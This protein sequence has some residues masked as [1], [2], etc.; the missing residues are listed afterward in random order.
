V[1]GAN[2]FVQDPKVNITQSTKSFGEL[3]KGYSGQ[4]DNNFRQNFGVALNVPIFSNGGSARNAYER[5]KLNVQNAQL[6]ITQADLQLKQDIYQAYT[7]ASAAMQRYNASI[8]TL[9]ATQKTYD[10]AK[11]RYDVG[12]LGTFELITNQNNLNKSIMDKLIAQY[13]YVF[14]MKV[15]EFYKGMGLK[16]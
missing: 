16:L 3:W 12:L 13:E 14:R 2:Y 5:S 7:T 1:G 6:V 9:A 8:T 15:L 11:K 10:F 4:L